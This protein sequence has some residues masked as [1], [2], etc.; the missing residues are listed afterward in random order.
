MLP[1]RRPGRRARGSS[2]DGAQGLARLSNCMNGA[3]VALARGGYVRIHAELFESHHF[4]LR[5]Q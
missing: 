3:S 1:E 5:Q 2:S 4:L